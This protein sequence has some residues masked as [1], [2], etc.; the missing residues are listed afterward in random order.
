MAEVKGKFITL[1]ADLLR[2]KPA[3]RSAA[4]G[5]VERMTGKTPF[6]LEP[7]GWYDTTV[8]DEVF[9]AID[10]GESPLVAWAVVKVIGQNLYPTIYAMGLPKDLRTPLDFLKFEAE[11]F[12]RNHRGSDVVPR[13]FIKT[14]T[15]CIIIEALSPGYNC[16][17]TEGVFDGILRMCHV[18]RGRVKQTKCVRKGDSTCEYS[19]QW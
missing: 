1:A 11:D 18:T 10:E 15:S 9:R 17:L 5:A 14:E 3:V 16:A 12:L 19:I 6:G 4:M 7:E 13:K 2:S 8:L